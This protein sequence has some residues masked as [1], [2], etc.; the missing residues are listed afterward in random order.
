M[1]ESRHNPITEVGK[2]V[3]DDNQ[4]KACLLDM[5]TKE[6]AIRE[7]TMCIIKRLRVQEHELSKLHAIL[8]MNHDWDVADSIALRNFIDTSMIA[9]RIEQIMKGKTEALNK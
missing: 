6:S 3:L 9:E 2:K 8:C 4:R 1:N 5:N 7:R